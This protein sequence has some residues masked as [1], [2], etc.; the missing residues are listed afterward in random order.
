MII[1]STHNK[2]HKLPKTIKFTLLIGILASFFLPLTTTGASEFDNNDNDIAIDTS[3]CINRAH[4]DE[5]E[6]KLEETKK[7]SLEK[8]NQ[9]ARNEDV[10]LMRGKLPRNQKELP[11]SYFWKIL[12]QKK[13]AGKVFI[14]PTDIDPLGRQPA[15]QIFLNKKAQGKHIGRIAYERAC[16]L[17]HYDVV[18]ATMRRNNIASYKAACAAGFREI[19]NSA[20]KQSVMKWV[21]KI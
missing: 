3:K 17:S 10:E 6:M 16:R 15:I 8:Q 18:Y 11:E 7:P 2:Q 20:F 21:R 9:C 1:S 12:F 14:E 13:S 4:F 19:K 5:V